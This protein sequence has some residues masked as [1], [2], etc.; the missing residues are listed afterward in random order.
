MKKITLIVASFFLVG[1]IANASEKVVFSD[2]NFISNFGFDEPIS[3]VERGIEF[4]IFP[5]GEFDF[6]TRPEDSHGNF[7]YKSAGRKVVINV[8]RNPVDYGVRIEHD[9]FGRV[10]RVGNTFINYDFNDRVTRI[11]SV[12]IKYNRFALVQVGG[13]KIVYNRNGQ[14]IDFFGSV[15]N[16]RMAYIDGNR[17]Y[18]GYNYHNHNNSNSN[19]E[20][21]N[22]DDYYY[23]TKDGKNNRK[24][25]DED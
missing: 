9:D 15:K 8:Q 13:L 4:Y 25:E 7:F 1:G 3:F 11:G 16:T 5:N 20:N 23:K 2:T 10:R 17:R 14:I 21:D 18:R 19:Y 12:F 22:D 6:N 24:K